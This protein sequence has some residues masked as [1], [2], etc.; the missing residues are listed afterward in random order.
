MKVAFRTFWWFSYIQ[1]PNFTCEEWI[2]HGEPISAVQFST[3]PSIEFFVLAEVLQN[4]A[5]AVIFRCCEI[6]KA[7]WK[8]KEDKADKGRGGKTTGQKWTG[9][10]FAK[11]LHMFASLQFSDI[12]TGCLSE[13]EFPTRLHASVSTPSPPPPL[14]ICLTFYICTLLL[15]LFAPVPTPASSRF[16]SISAWQKMI[17][18]SL[19]LVLLSGTHCHCTL[20]MLQLLTPSSLL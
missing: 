12:F 9:L 2:V 11:F 7:Q 14:L 8:G 5:M 15:G 16:H 18:L 17:V 20:E 6:C 3:V 13:P 19:T 4:F 1:S 10:K